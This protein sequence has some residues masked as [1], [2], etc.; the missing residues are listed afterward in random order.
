MKQCTKCGR[1]YDDSSLQYCTDDGTPLTPRFDSEAETVK[2]PEWS[3]TDIE[4]EI[5]DSLRRLQLRVGD[6]R[7]VRFEDL[8]PLGLTLKQISENFPAAVRRAALE[9]V[10]QTETRATVRKP[11]PPEV[12]SFSIPNTPVW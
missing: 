5:A 11:E 12:G 7:L 1:E 2:V 10:S 6:E 3:P 9:L 4:M 8:K